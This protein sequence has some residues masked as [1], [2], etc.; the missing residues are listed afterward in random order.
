MSLVD[1]SARA[2][3]GTHRGA[4]DQRTSADD[5]DHLQRRLAA[6]A[7]GVQSVAAVVA[8]LLVAAR[9]ERVRTFSTG[10]HGPLEALGL[11]LVKVAGPDH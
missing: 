5:V 11:A 1:G 7:S 9:A 2:L 10:A 6:R 8:D 3:V 4:L